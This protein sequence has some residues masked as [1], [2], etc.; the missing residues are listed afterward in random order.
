LNGSVISARIRKEDVEFF[1]ESS[2]NRVGIPVHKF[3]VKGIEA[4]IAHPHDLHGIYV[5]LMAVN[6]RYF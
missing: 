3:D 4:S 5:A 6:D 2:I 1:T